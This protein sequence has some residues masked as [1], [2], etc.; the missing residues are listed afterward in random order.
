MQPSAFNQSQH[1][2]LAVEIG[3]LLRKGALKVSSPEPEE[4]VSPIFLRPKP[5]GSY[6]MIINLKLFNE[7]T[8]Y[9]HFKMDALE[10][11]VRMMKPGC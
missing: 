7:F 3:K 8:Q 11:A 6:R 1:D 9:C 2:I 4:F 10:S 5:D